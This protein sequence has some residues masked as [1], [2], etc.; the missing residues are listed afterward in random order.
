[1]KIAE[2]LRLG[3]QIGI[4]E[5][6]YHINLFAEYLSIEFD[7]QG[8]NSKAISRMLNLQFLQLISNHKNKS[9]L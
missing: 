1:M 7:S 4:I 3:A 9:K 8:K 6:P 5:K 2:Y